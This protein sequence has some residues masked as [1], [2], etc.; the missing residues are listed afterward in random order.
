MQALPT[1]LP[2]L[3]RM[4]ERC[5]LQALT[6]FL[7]PLDIV[8]RNRGWPLLSP[9]VQVRYLSGWRKPHLYSI[10]L[11]QTVQPQLQGKNLY[12]DAGKSTTL[13]LSH[14]VNEESG[15]PIGIVWSPVPGLWHR[16]SSDDERSF[17]SSGILPPMRQMSHTG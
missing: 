7:E 3:C 8:G 13:F 12:P 17:Q 11:P 6:L 14:P 1:A 15:E 2:V 5:T 16:L 10:A 9:D 4:P